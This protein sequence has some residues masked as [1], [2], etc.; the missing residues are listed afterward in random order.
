MTTDRTQPLTTVRLVMEPLRVDHA[1]EMVDVLADP[2]L[3][4]H[5]GGTPPAAPELQERYRR[6]VEG[7]GSEDELWFNW[8]ARRL[9]DGVAVGFVQATVEGSVADV[10]WLIGTAHQRQGFATEAARAMLQRL[11]STGTTSFTAHIAP[12]HTSSQ[13]VAQALGFERTE[14]VDDDG[15]HV[16]AKGSA[17]S[18]SR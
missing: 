8:V 5:T 3:Y 11:A 17:T 9:E 14:V 15:E 6:Q 4:E 13:R 10:A 1:D 16:W 2:A 18:V 12:G 7:S